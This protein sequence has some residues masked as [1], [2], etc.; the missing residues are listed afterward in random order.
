MRRQDKE[1]KGSKKRKEKV[2]TRG[3]QR[4]YEAGGASQHLYEHDTSDVVKM[5][6]CSPIHGVVG[7]CDHLHS[8]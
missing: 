6:F 5:V 2:R 7:D 8:R 1:G 3:E 4:F